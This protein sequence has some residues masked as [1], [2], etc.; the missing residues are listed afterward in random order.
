M[1]VLDKPVI[2]SRSAYGSCASFRIL[3]I[4]KLLWSH[5]ILRD[6]FL[7]ARKDSSRN[8]QV[9][10]V[11]AREKLALAQWDYQV[12]TSVMKFRPDHKNRYVNYNARAK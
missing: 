3:N 10:V 9:P 6:F 5:R 1:L 7:L 8:T 4:G 12:H 11:Y 2:V